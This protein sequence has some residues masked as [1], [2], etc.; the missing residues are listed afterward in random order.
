MTRPLPTRPA[1]VL[2]EGESLV[3]AYVMPV[4]ESAIAARALSP[5]VA[6]R[7]LAGHH[8]PFGLVLGCQVM[9]LV[10]GAE[11]AQVIAHADPPVPVLLVSIQLWL[12]LTRTAHRPGSE[13]TVSVPFDPSRVFAYLAAL[14]QE[15]EAA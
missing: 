8:R 2:V 11:L 15:S 9:H 12:A 5:A 6:V 4:P 10:G 7:L 3:Q 1:F 14:R 13:P